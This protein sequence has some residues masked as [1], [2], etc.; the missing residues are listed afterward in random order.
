MDR[1]FYYII[2]SKIKI[3]KM[4]TGGKVCVTQFNSYQNGKGI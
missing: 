3:L 1:S 2:I 4:K